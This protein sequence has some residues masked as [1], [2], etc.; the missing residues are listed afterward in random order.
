MRETGTC[1]MQIEEGLDTGAVYDRRVVPIEPHDTAA[2]LR[3]RLVDA[4]SGSSSIAFERG[5]S[6]PDA[7]KSA[8]RPMPARSRADELRLDW[9]RPAAELDRLVRLGGAWTTFRGKRLKV[10]AANLAE[11]ERHAA[12]PGV[13]DGPVGRHRHSAACNSTSYSR[14]A[15]P[16]GRPLVDQRQP[17]RPNRLS[18]EH[19]AS[20]LQTALAARCPVGQHTLGR[21]PPLPGHVETARSVAYSALL[22]VDHDGAYA[23][24]Q[25]QQSLAA[26]GL[27]TR[28]KA[29]A[30]EFVYGATRMRRAC[31]FAIDRHVLKP[32]SAA[33]AYSAAAR[34]V[35]AAVHRRPPPT[36]PS[37]RRS[38]LPRERA[39]GFVNAILRNDL[40][41]RRCV[42]PN[43][44]TR[45][46]YPDWIVRATDRRTRRR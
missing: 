34:R 42:W 27:D 11:H 19:D 7:R 17:P 39:R 20:S 16:H 44:A 5:L 32:P 37:A 6:S 36:P 26:C 15:R 22:E 38:T 10:I 24:L 25:M 18:S 4:G 9:T 40:A 35:P 3:H 13:I 21:R 30:T 12:K 33:A 29:F 8:S 23:N 41:T 14:K 28:D 45:L 31:D 46:S 1:L 2:A 43:E